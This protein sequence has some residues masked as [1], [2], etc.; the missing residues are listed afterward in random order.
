[1]LS[2]ESLPFIEW[3]LEHLNYF[4]ITLLMTI[5]SSFIPFPSEVVIP[6]AAYMAASSGDLNVYL[7]VFFGTLGAVFGALINYGLAMW[8]GRPLIYRF[9]NSRLGAVCLIDSAKVEKAEGF[10]ARNGSISTFVGRLIPGIRQLISIPAGLARMSLSKFILFT[11]L[12]GGIWNA[13]L[14]ALGYYAASIVP[15]EQLMDYIHQHSR[16]V[17]LV[18]VAVVVVVLAVFIYK[19]IKKPKEV[20]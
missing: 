6:P 7:V 17:S 20:A 14:A 9:A 11:A 19:A 3:C 18:I 15:R 4:T 16:E 5:E 13:V 2:M 8:L 1:M 12:G 10:F